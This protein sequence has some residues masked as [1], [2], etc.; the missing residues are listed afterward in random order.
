MNVE[1]KAKEVTISANLIWFPKITQVFTR[2]ADIPAFRS[3]PVRDYLRSVWIGF[4]A[5]I[6]NLPYTVFVILLNPGRISLLF[7]FAVLTL[8][9]FPWAGLR[10]YLYGVDVTVD[11]AITL[12]ELGF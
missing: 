10:G 2:K 8:W 11:E 3:S 5:P 1:E 6:L 12:H 9:G 7:R 4:T